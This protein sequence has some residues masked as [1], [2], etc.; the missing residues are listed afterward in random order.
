MYDSFP[1]H[2]AILTTQC[3]AAT[4][5]GFGACLPEIFLGTSTLKRFLTIFIVSKILQSHS[6][7]YDAIHGF[8]GMQRGLHGGRHAPT[9]TLRLNVNF[10]E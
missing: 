7:V 3:N 8:M 2:T 5:G 6:K 9:D 1:K 4:S 10:F